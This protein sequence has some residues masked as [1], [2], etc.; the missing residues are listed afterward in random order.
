MYQANPLHVH[1]QTRGHNFKAFT[2]VPKGI[3]QVQPLLKFS[4]VT[5]NIRTIY[6]VLKLR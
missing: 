6:I 2:P 4:E 1:K 5:E 3:K